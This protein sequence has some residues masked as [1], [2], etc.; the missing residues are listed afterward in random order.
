MRSFALFALF[1][2][3]AFALADERLAGVACRSV[4]LAYEGP[5][6]DLFTS[7]VVVRKSAPGT[8]FCVCGFGKGYFGIQELADGKRLAIFSVWDPAAGDDPR[9]VK[10]E[11][12]VKLLDKDPAVRTGRFGGEGTGGQSFFDFPWKEGTPYRF[13]VAARK[14]G[15]RTIYSGSF[16]APEEMKWRKLATF[17]TPTKG[18]LV[19]G[20][21]SFVE[22]FRRNRVSAT[23]ERRAEYGGGWIRADGK[24]IALTRARFTADSNPAL[25]IDAGPL[26]DRFFLATGGKTENVTAKL[27][28]QFD[29]LPAGV[30]L[31]ATTMKK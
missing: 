13:L 21:Y 17:S 12:R 26:G 25:N 11:A 7:E 23:E 30:D 6:A 19:R 10:P 24:W 31:P 29:R 4:H 2:T 22:D 8:Y 1:M 9:K 28:S 27:R 16:F 18:E 20:C 14:D 5:E 15:D 3:P